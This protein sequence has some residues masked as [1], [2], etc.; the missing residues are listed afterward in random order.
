MDIYKHFKYCSI[1]GFN[2]HSRQYPNNGVLVYLKR[3]LNHNSH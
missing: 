2:L 3:E 1:S